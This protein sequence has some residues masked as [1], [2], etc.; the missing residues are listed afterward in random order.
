[1]TWRV[2][3]HQVI[4]TLCFAW[5]SSISA[6]AQLPEP[7][8][9]LWSNPLDS[10]T[11]LSASD[12][13]GTL[14]TVNGRTSLRIGQTDG[15][16]S[17]LRTF[18]L[19]V[20][21][22]RGKWV[23]LNAAVKAANISPKALDWNGIK[24]MLKVERPS[25]TQWPQVSIPAG[26]FDWNDRSTR[27][28]IPGDAVSVTLFLGVELVTGTAW[29]DDIRITLSRA[30]RDIPAAPADQPV[31]RGHHLPALRGAMAHPRM[32]HEDMRVFAQDWGGNLLRWQLVR[33]P[34]PEIEHD[35]AIYD[36]WLTD[37]LNYLDLVLGWAKELGVMI[38]VDLH[39]PPGGRIGGGGMAGANGH[40]WS[41][42]AAQDHFIAAWQRITQ[43]YKDNP[44]IWGFDLLNE[45]DDREVSW[46][47]VDWQT[48]S[49]RA[50][51]AVRAIDQDRTLIIEP[52]MWGSAEGFL[53]FEPLD[54]PGIVYSFHVY[55]PFTYTHQSL[56][57]PSAPIPYPGQIDGQQWDKA[58]LEASM[59]P[60]IAFAEKYRVHMYIGEF[61]A[62]R[63]AP[64]VDTYL[65]DA[66]GIFESHRWDWTYHSF[67]E[68]HGWNLELGTDR[69]ELAPIPSPN[70]R[71][72]A[73]L[74]KTKKN[75]RPQTN[76]STKIFPADAV[77]NITL[78]PYNAHPDDGIDDT[79]AIQQAIKDVTD[80]TDTSRFIYFPAGT[81]L[82]SN[83]LVSKNSAGLWRAMVTLQGEDRG[84]TIL[85]LS[86]HATGFG[87]PAIPKAILMTGSIMDA[88]EP[89]T[90]GGGNKAF[91][92][93]VMDL[94]IDTGSGNPGAIGIEW[95][96]SNWGTI[97]D[98]T[99]RSGD[100]AGQAGL[101]M[102]RRIP[103]P[104]YVKRVTIEGFNY[105]IDVSDIQYGF[106]L[107]HVHAR[108]QK[109]AGIR[110]DRNLLHIRKLTSDNVVPAI[111]TTHSESALTLIDCHFRGTPAGVH[112]VETSGNHLLVTNLTLDPPA[113]LRTRGQIRAASGSIAKLI[114]PS[115]VSTDPSPSIQEGPSLPVE[116][117]PDFWNK[118][119]SDWKSV[120]PRLAGE[121]DDTA[122]IQRA[123]DSGKSTVY[124][125]INRTY[126]VSDTLIVRG[127]LRQFLGMG[128]EISLGAAQQSFGNPAAPRP[129]F[130]ID[131]TSHDEVFFEHLF[132]NTQYPGVVVFENNSPKTVVIRHSGGWIGSGMHKRSYHNTANATG[133]V[134]V[135][136]VFMPGWDF[137]GQQ[138]WARQLNPE[139]QESDGSLPQVRNSGGSLWILGFKTEGQA[140]F[141]VTENHAATE[142]LGAY[143]YISATFTAPVPANAVPY[144]IKD[145]RA[146]LSFTTDNFREDDYP[147]YIRTQNGSHTKDWTRA[148]MPTRNGAP[149]YKSFS[150][151]WFH[152][153][154]ATLDS[155]S[156]RYFTP[157]QRNDTQVS[158]P[159]ATP[160][161]DGVA[162][163]LKYHLGLDPWQR[164]NGF[165]P[166]M[167][168]DSTNGT[169]VLRYPRAA[170]SPD[171]SGTIEWSTTLRGDD[172]HR[173]GVSESSTS[174]VSNLEQ[175]VFSISKNN[176]DR[177]FLRLKVVKTA[178]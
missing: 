158:G 39:S 52:N 83:T 17:A 13:K 72:Q 117:A 78:P 88:G 45:P 22:L 61:S 163:L 23:F 60:A 3:S 109:I 173:E 135:E 113:T 24:V 99:I 44:T 111:V 54:L 103:G 41:T 27:I 160:A 40:F 156:D 70:P 12:G 146:F 128:S 152:W 49:E 67:R 81:Y 151:P 145:S 56:D 89:D 38:V 63:W 171:A 58:T 164:D 154:D 86:D 28:L 68:W 65:K 101:S 106:T 141:I 62:I 121:N 157:T 166:I 136:D 26:T 104:G 116:D 134:F 53:G 115:L 129:V 144:V 5:V 93:N 100:G 19:P 69:N 14:E 82:V 174:S 127:S 64:G 51:I 7:G 105:G 172:W 110:L 30:V 77:I 57:S 48:L 169:F 98:V 94:T 73:I 92:N 155:W 159:L 36:Q 74:D 11:D 46:D 80:V 29:F 43:R 84:R 20:E 35:L 79:A 42:P 176:R 118:D 161:G 114:D 6:W 91:R 2:R 96:A 16:T 76:T 124:L 131:P 90:G 50:A 8:D 168:S 133:K 25:D 149:G 126:F 66:I 112:A 59:A 87:D 132:L 123:I 102:R 140:P 21:S 139:N 31:F 147:V 162:N 108:D 4:L 18:N 143:H 167:E 85:K 37:E 32:T 165:K 33:F 15:T 142:L 55:T 9:V 75:A 71:L 175:A 119:L 122:A 137:S 1:M 120:G 47:G 150:L 107:E 10:P 170:H 130:R 177:L 153:S 138:V 34:S 178:P 97:K 95:A 148:Q 125:P